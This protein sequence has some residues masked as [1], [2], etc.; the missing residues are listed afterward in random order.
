MGKVSRTKRERRDGKEAG[1][2]M[3]RVA[4]GSPVDPGADGVIIDP[5]LIWHP[6]SEPIDDMLETLDG[7]TRRTGHGH[8]TVFRD[9]VAFCDGVLRTLPLHLRQ[10]ALK[11][12][13]VQMPQDTPDDVRQ[14]WRDLDQRYGQHT[15]LALQQFSQVLW[16]LM[17]AAST[18]VADWL[19]VMFMRWKLGNGADQFF[20][21]WN[22]AK[23]MAEM[24]LLEQEVH[25][26]VMAALED[27]RNEAGK[28]LRF[29]LPVAAAM[30]EA[31]QQE[32]W[33]TKLLPAALPY[34]KPIPFIDTC[35]GSGVMLLAASTTVPAWANRLGIVNYF[36]VDLDPFCA[37]MTR[38]QCML[39]GLNGYQANLEL[40]LLDALEARGITLPTPEQ[41][42]AWDDTAAGAADEHAAADPPSPQRPRRRGL[43]RVPE[44]IV[45]VD[46]P[47][48]EDI[49]T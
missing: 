47:S 10:A 35:C 4:P 36:G 26:A 43:R 39:Y 46:T 1:K 42:Q 6:P 31:G 19:G 44:G 45:V 41:R 24:S 21:P 32:F 9:W 28:I 16:Q 49:I 34:I 5:D 22:A 29:M 15:D 40:S 30:S 7:I 14:V 38:V 33:R 20:T 17:Q 12:S 13:I 25:K 8:N 37:L 23:L 18:C 2:G 3:R 48:E 27:E 11:E